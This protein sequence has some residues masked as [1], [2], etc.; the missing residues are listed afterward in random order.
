MIPFPEFNPT[1]LSIGTLEIRWY[2]LLYVIS[3]IV[4]HIFLKKLYRKKGISITNEQYENL[5][6]ILML[7]VIIG[8]RFGYIIF[9][10][11]PYYIQNPLH[12][13]AVWEGGMSF[14]GGLLG[15][16]FGGIIFAKKN[17]FNFYALADPV[18]P[19]SAVGIGLVRWGNFMN[20][21]L[22]GRVTNVPWSMIFPNSDG[23][24]RHPSQLYELFGEGILLFLISFFLLK[25]N[26]KNGFVFWSFIGLYGMFRFFI[27]F[28]RQPDEHLGFILGPFT[29]GQILCFFMIA[30][31][32][33]GLLLLHKNR[34]IDIEN[35]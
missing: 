1:I 12:I 4:G 13:F 20:G 25:K 6:F 26:L 28:T 19:L 21:E 30:G 24:P 23:Q 3:F 2:G 29:M 18:M 27:E 17:R 5:M 10:H 7:G 16:I 32:L 33:V 35:N 34:K 31:S 22:Y 14:H 9:Y 15:V 8:G 11:L